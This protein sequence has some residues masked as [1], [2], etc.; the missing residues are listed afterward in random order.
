MK[1]PSTDRWLSGAASF[2]ARYNGRARTKLPTRVLSFV[3][4]FVQKCIHTS[5]SD[6]TRPSVLPELTEIA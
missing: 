3:G 6:G 1:I 2:K 5:S 4:H